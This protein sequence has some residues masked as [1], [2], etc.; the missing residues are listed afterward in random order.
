MR[1]FTMFSSIGG[2]KLRPSHL[3][4]K[5]ENLP[6]TGGFKPQRIS[7][8][9]DG[10]QTFY[11]M[12][13][14][15]R[16]KSIDNEPWFVGKDVADALGYSNP[17]KAM[18]DHVDDED[19]LTER[20]VLSGQR[21]WMVIINESGMYSL[22]LQ[23]QLKEAKKFKRWV[24]HD[25]IPAIRKTGGYG[26]AKLPDFAERY[27]LNC[28][29]IPYNYFSVLNEMWTQVYKEFEKAGYIL[30]DVSEIGKAL[31]PDISVGKCF[32]KYL[33][34]MGFQEWNQCRKYLHEF[35]DGRCVKALMYPVDLL[36]TF[37]RY[38][39][40]EWIPKRASAYLKSRDPKALEYLPKLLR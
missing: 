37:I 5:I 9:S 31:M 33:R 24:T 26:R 34:A 23:S 30:P 16:V 7:W 6:D 38:V 2:L 1:H 25:V 11:F 27:K 12:G 19:K 32:A 4:S 39:H 14:P 18:R 13:L 15:V 35:A 20:F 40:E 8:F 3:L 28:N 29:K 17:Q 10:F 22:T 21:R 36:P